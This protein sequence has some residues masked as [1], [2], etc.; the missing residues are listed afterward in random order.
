MLKGETIY[1]RM[2]EPED[3]EQ[4]HKWH[5]DIDIQRFTCGPV[6]IVSKEIEKAWVS[7]KATNNRNDLYLAICLNSDDSMIG[8]TSISDIDNFNQSCAWSGLVIGE[9]KHQDGF[10]FTECT[11]L[12]LHY[13]FTQMNMHRVTDKCLVKHP[14]SNALAHACH[15]QK[16]GIERSAI[17]KNGQF[18][19]VCTYSL[20]KDEY[21]Q[22]YSDGDYSIYSLMANIA[23][24]IKRLKNNKDALV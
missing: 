6:R 21:F 9:K 22:Y 5:N 13:I 2:L 24:H 1:L 23:R 12:V 15:F 8:Y 3:W 10:A 4:T 7:S 17:Y 16:E 14:L 19:D 18:N 20:L 11:G